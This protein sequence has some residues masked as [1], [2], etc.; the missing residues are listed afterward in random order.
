LKA[1]MI[2]LISL[3]VGITDSLSMPSFQTIVPSLVGK[4]E[5]PQAVSLNSIQ[6]NLSRTLGPALAGVMIA[7]AGALACFE[8]NAISFIPFFLSVIWI[9]PKSE[10][11]NKSDLSE[12]EASGSTFAQFKGVLVEK[13]IQHQLLTILVTTMFCS[14]LVTFC[15]VVVKELFSGQVAEFGNASAAFGLGGLFGAIIAYFSTSRLTEQSPGFFGLAM[16][17]IVLAVAFNHSLILLFLLM[18]A[19]GLLLTL[20][21]TAAN[22]NLQLR[23][24]DHARG[25]YASLYQLAFR[26]GISLGGL[27]TG[28]VAGHLGIMTALLLNGLLAVSIH[29]GLLIQKQRSI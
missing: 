26:G 24:N 17:F 12:K 29:F 2:I 14:P 5:I 22:S 28:A 13:G 20:A 23:A 27:L 9:Y 7:Q 1:W 16:G 15:P 19:G 4:K 21:N 11:E 3:T 25:K 18:T 8:A 6:F 10:P